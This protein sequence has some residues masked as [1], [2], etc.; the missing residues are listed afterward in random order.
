MADSFYFFGGVAVENQFDLRS[1]DAGTNEW[2]VEYSPGSILT[3]EISTR[4]PPVCRRFSFSL[5]SFAQRFLVLFGGAGAFIEK[6]QRRETFND[7]MVWDTHYC[8]WI[9][10]RE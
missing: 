4:N 2:K 8:K 9:D 7:I 5:C 1:Y 3:E 10:P 6:V